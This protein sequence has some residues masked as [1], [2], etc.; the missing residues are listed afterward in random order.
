MPE[1]G[2]PSIF[3]KNLLNLQTENL[4]NQCNGVNTSFIVSV[5]YDEN[6]IYVYF[7]GIRVQSG[8]GITVT[9]NTTFTTLFTPSLSDSLYV[10]FQPL[11]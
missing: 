5:E 6:K 7:N 11:T 8:N 4:S 3:N 10:D 9:S 1:I 2:Y